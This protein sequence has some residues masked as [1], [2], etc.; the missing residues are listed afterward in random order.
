MKSRADQVL[1]ER[2]FF[3][4]RA[5]AQAAIAAGLVTANGVAVRKASEMVARS[6]ALTAEAPHPYVSRGGLKLEAA[7][8]VFGFDPKGRVCLDVGSS[9]GGFTDLLLQRG[10]RHVIAVDVGRDQLHASL[11][12]D[13]RVS[14]FEGQD[15][16]L[17]AAEALPERPVLAA[18]DVSFISLKLVLPAVAALL[19]P[20]AGIA[21][22]IKPQFEA[23]RAALKKGIV[24][25]EAVQK[26]VCDEIVLLLGE[27]GF[28]VAG[29]IPSPIEGGDGNREF[30][31]GARRGG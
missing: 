30:L 18:I 16:R 17:L 23:G 19:A 28:R 29:P 9:T 5:R 11:R 7:L 12:G 20:Q 31:A 15:I 8:D 1:V 24:R 26:Q 10:A 22:L 3:E 6:A 2:G 14:S 27:L 25:D 21:A 4:S 13:P